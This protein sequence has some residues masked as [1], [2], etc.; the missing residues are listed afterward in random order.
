MA[1]TAIV[2]LLKEL[3]ID[4]QDILEEDDQYTIFKNSIEF[5]YSILTNSQKTWL[6]VYFWKISNMN[7]SKMKRERK[8]GKQRYDINYF[9]ELYYSQLSEIAD[10]GINNLIIALRSQMEVK[11]LPTTLLDELLVIFKDKLS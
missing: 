4:N 8:R 6:S 5:D 7:S 10:N 3:K 1:T 11:S 2:E 9:N